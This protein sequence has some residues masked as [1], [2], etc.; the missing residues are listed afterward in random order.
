M[1][2]KKLLI[3]RIV[4]VI[5]TVVGSIITALVQRKENEKNIKKFVDENMNKS[6]E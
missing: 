5:A 1:K 6:G 3:F 4:G 2:D